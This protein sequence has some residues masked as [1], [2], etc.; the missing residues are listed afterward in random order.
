[1]LIAFYIAIGF[2]AYP[3]IGILHISVNIYFLNKRAVKSFHF[4]LTK[5]RSMSIDEKLEMGTSGIE[6]LETAVKDRIVATTNEKH[7]NMLSSALIYPI[8]IVSAIIK[9]LIGKTKSNDRQ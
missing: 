4:E 7:L 8:V 1:M 2:I 6:Q 5:I 9:W 3:I